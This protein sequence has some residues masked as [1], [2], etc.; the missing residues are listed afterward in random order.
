MIRAL[1][2][3]ASAAA[4]LL[5]SPAG[6]QTPPD[7]DWAATTRTDVEAAYA[8]LNDNHPGAL[9]QIGDT[10]FRRR[11][12][13]GRA[14]ALERAARV[15]GAGG[16]RAVLNAF[17]GGMGDRHIA[18]QPAGPASW[19]WA[20]LVFRKA[21]AEWRVSAHE[22]DPGEADL[23]DAVLVDCDGAAAEATAQA[24]LDGFQLDWSVEA[25]RERR[26]A[27]LLLDNGNPLLNRPATCRFETADGTVERAMRWREITSQ[28]LQPL[29][30]AAYRGRRAGM[31]LRPFAGGDWIA[32]QT[33]GDGASAVVEAV[34]ADAAR[35][36]AS[37]VVVLDMRGNGG[38]SSML[39]RQIAEAL[40][41]RAFVQARTA[42]NGTCGAVWRAS[43]DN[44][45][46]LRSWRAMAAERGP[47]F[48]AWLEASIASVE[49]ANVAGEPTDAPITDCDPAPARAGTG[50]ASLMQGRLILI[51]DESCFSSCLIVTD[52]F[53][54]LGALHLGHATDRA[55]RY[56]EVRAEPLPSGLGAFSTLQK[57]ALGEMAT[58][59]FPP[60]IV[61]DGPM[62]DDAALEAWVM[63]A[64]AGRR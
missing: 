13:E 57:M 49:R 8:L 36:R 58:G 64:V 15:S 12:D 11:L 14:L 18:F 17:A 56:M 41:G 62:H 6:A 19:T 35:L 3:V 20:G 10:D 44:L 39:G 30:N 60:D 37:P 24:W 29:L 43:D 33:L 55:T 63:E 45:A 26:G 21:G 59:P 4:A 5:A 32:L 48:A 61:H 53:R 50:P 23:A 34:R 27:L 51:T 52:D 38:G 31:G 47:E 28:T 40:M 46:S 9:P 25:Q 16:H 22:P 7:R 42:G 1:V 54:R 2:L